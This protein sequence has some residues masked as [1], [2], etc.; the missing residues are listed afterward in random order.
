MPRYAAI[1][2]LLLLWDSADAFAQ[3]TRDSAGIRIVENARPRSGLGAWRIDPRPM[4]TIG[5]QSAD[6]DT[7]QELNLV[8]GITRLRDGRWAVGVQASNTVRFYDAQGRMTGFVGRRG[9]GPGEFRQ[10]MGVY[11]M[12]GD[13]LVVTDLGEVEL[14]TADGKFVRQG[15]SRARGDRF[16]YPEAVLPDGSYLGL[17]WPAPSRSAPEAGR[18]RRTLPLVRVSRDGEQID[19]VGTFIGSE[20]IYDG[21]QPFGNQVVFS[22]A[23]MIAADD[24]RFFVSSV[25]RFEIVES[26]LA[27]RPV[28]IIRV[29]KPAVRVS[30]E[31]KRDYREWAMSMTGEDGRPMPP[32]MQERRRQA[33]ERAQWAET[34]PPF[35]RMIIDRTGNLWV[36]AFDYHRVFLTPGPVRTQTMTVASQWDV[37]DRSGAL[38]TSI[39]LPP[40]FTPV[41]IGADYVA[42]L[43][44]DQ[45]DVEQVRV[46]RLIKTNS[47]P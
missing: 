35:A 36:Q 30:E 27:G 10:V 37:F 39:E 3:S 15:A 6:L 28:R 44:R 38:L 16:V 32:A 12:R 2:L 41:E 46:Y 23:T 43:G 31:A 25:D 20:E 17:H 29:T 42:G 24:A 47:S 1:P 26:T 8:M 14:F 40:R 9:E 45:D 22:G 33:L 19:T 13:T 34:F 4:L 5:G 11:A 18:S 7:L 21:R